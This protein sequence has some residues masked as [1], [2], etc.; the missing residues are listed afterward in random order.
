MCVS[1]V[2]RVF[3]H[4]TVACDTELLDVLD[5][6][7]RWLRLYESLHTYVV[8]NGSHRR[9]ASRYLPRTPVRDTHY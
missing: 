9:S 8:Q 2:L 4:A 3:L 1:R 7:I 5:T 6:K